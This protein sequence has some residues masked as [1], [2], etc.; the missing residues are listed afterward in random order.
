M[1]NPAKGSKLHAMTYP[2]IDDNFAIPT[3]FP[4]DDEI[5]AAIDEMAAQ[6]MLATLK[7][8]REDG[9]TNTW[10]KYYAPLQKKETNG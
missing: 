2:G 3:D 5:A 1:T 4:E 10:G 8:L 7:A 9:T 6:V